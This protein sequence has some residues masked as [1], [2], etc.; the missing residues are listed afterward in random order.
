MCAAG[1]AAVDP[2]IRTDER[3]Q[4][5]RRLRKIDE[6][7]RGVLDGATLRWVAQLMEQQNE[8]AVLRSPAHLMV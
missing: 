2:L 6:E 7:G 4:W 1:I 5:A 3:S 8:R